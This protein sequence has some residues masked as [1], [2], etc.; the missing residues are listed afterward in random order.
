MEL[1]EKLPVFV[2]KSGI[3]TGNV[4]IFNITNY[5]MPLFAT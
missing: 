2:K 4:F 3:I 5:N 1:Y